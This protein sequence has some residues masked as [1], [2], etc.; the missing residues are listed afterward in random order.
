[1]CVP[2]DGCIPIYASLKFE[3]D[4]A[5]AAFPVL[6]EAGGVTRGAKITGAL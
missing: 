5:G 6:G 2:T 3:G 1:M 4:F